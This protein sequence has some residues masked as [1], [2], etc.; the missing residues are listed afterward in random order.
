M[1]SE[2]VET[3]KV[4]VEAVNFTLASLTAETVMAIECRS[5]TKVVLSGGKGHRRCGLAFF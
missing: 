2:R 4:A 1:E 3:V 5:T